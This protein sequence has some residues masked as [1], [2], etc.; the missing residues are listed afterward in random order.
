MEESSDVD[1]PMSAHPSP[2]PVRFP[3]LQRQNAMSLPVHADG[4]GDRQTLP[5]LLLGKITKRE[6]MNKLIV[7]LNY[8]EAATELGVHFFRK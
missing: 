5:S 2:L 3:P 4:T 1:E 6:I 7:S 8:I